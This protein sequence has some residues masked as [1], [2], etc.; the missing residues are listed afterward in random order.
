MGGIPEER[1]FKIDYSYVGGDGVVHDVIG[2]IY[3]VGDNDLPDDPPERASLVLGETGPD[4]IPPNGATAPNVIPGSVTVYRVLEGC[5]LRAADLGAGAR[6]TAAGVIGYYYRPLGAPVN[7]VAMAAPGDLLRVD[8]SIRGKRQALALDEDDLYFEVPDVLNYE[9]R[10]PQ[11][12]QGYAAALPMP[13]PAVVPLAEDLPEGL[14][15]AMI[16]LSRGEVYTPLSVPPSPY[17]LAVDYRS[18]SVSVRE[19]VPPPAGFA[20]E[21]KAV[22]FLYRA[23]GQWA[24]QPVLSA[25]RYAVMVQN[26]VP[27]GPRTLSP[28]ALYRIPAPATA[29]EWSAVPSIEIGEAGFSK[30][31]WLQVRDNVVDVDGVDYRST[32]LAMPPDRVFYKGASVSVD[33]A[34][35][36]DPDEDP[37]TEEKVSVPVYGE[38]HVLDILRADRSG[39]E[40]PP[41]E[42]A[43]W[44]GFRLHHPDLG[45]RKEGLTEVDPA[46]EGVV[47]IRAIRGLS[48]YM[49]SFWRDPLDRF[50][51]LPHPVTG[52]LLA[53]R[54]Y[55]STQV[56]S[57][58]VRE[59][60]VR[61]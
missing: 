35:V 34:Y 25:A 17:A 31:Y 29:P 40:S 24:V 51:M 10:L 56:D 49:R 7:Q 57:G 55:A 12:L 44:I 22:R 32:W 60:L 16:D 9:T 20:L 21:G 30:Q 59:G 50:V 37:Q 5:L 54:V 39:H 41:D 58:A 42:M 18:G 33:Y 27:D 23:E 61:D 28:Q 6:A 52:T 4:G 43:G 45:N 8:Y 46:L 15:M 2:E 53:S 14:F 48:V 38:V 1:R 26:I 13:L 36:Y 19:L 47:E 11:D 3:V